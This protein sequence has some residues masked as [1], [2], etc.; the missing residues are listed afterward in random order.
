MDNQKFSPFN[1]TIVL[2]S[3]SPRRAQL[4]KDA[5]FIFR[6]QP[7]D[8]NEDFPEDMPLEEVASFLAEKKALATDTGQLMENE[9]LL[10]ADS[11]VIIN[12][13]IL[14]KPTD[15]E[16]AKNMLLQLSNQ[17]HKVFTGVCLQSKNKKRLFS[18]ETTVHFGTLTEE[19]IDFYIQQSKPFDK[20]GSYGIQDWIGFCKIKKIEG[21]YANV[22][23][24]PV[25]AI[26]EALLTF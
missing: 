3:K 10:T 5:G 17:S 11:V 6:I 12:K 4:L 8:V 2:A 18:N 26:Y 7:I 24:L 21:E 20:A 23:G 16:E 25:C 22:M 9:I 1:K 15:A 19:E 13:K 14:N